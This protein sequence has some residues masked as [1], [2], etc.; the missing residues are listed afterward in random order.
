MHPFKVTRKGSACS[1]R[2]QRCTGRDILQLE[3]SNKYKCS[4]ALKISDKIMKEF[5]SRQQDTGCP[6]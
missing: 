1:L 4:Q 3:F 2:K 6:I 5:K